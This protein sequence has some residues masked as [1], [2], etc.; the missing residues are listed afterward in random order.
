[1]IRHRIT[2]QH[3]VQ[4]H[5]LSHI[6]PITFVSFLVDVNDKVA[7]FE[8]FPVLCIHV[9]HI[10]LELLWS[11]PCG[12]LGLV[13]C[14]MHNQF[15]CFWDRLHLA[16]GRVWPRVETFSTANLLQLSHLKFAWISLLPTKQPQGSSVDSHER[17]SDTWALK[18]IFPC[19]RDFVV[20]ILHSLIATIKK[21][22]AFFP[23]L[24]TSFLYSVS[25]NHL[26]LLPLL[27]NQNSIMPCCV[28]STLEG[29]R[30][31]EIIRHQSNH[32]T[33]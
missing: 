26:V 2:H 5:I 27:K 28:P 19:H 24:S 10:C 15:A 17:T 13:G 33:S 6:W 32:F 20:N 16:W 22:H 14:S 1:M 18:L 30:D 23:F 8:L 9:H 11:W 7:W 4:Q 25:L 29:A 12:F 31:T 21:S 3:S